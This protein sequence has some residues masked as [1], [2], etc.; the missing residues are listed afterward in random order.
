MIIMA[1]QF[2]WVFNGPLT[3]SYHLERKCKK[4]GPDLRQSISIFYDPIKFDST[5]V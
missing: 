4:P 2:V 3:F 1:S 5:T